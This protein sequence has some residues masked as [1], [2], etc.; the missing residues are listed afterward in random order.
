MG[1]NASSCSELPVLSALEELGSLGNT[2]CETKL[3][4]NPSQQGLSANQLSPSISSFER[5]IHERSCAALQ[6]DRQWRQAGRVCW[7]SHVQDMGAGAEKEPWGSANR[8]LAMHGS[9]HP[10]IPLSEYPGTAWGACAA[11]F[12]YCSCDWV[13][14]EIVKV[15]FRLRIGWEDCINALLLM[16]STG[17]PTIPLEKSQLSGEG[18]FLL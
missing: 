9:L 15:S 10:K 13:D 14:W 18:K 5:G 17:K 7:A 12:L 4:D 6:Q 2:V 16:L 3:R 11:K 8:Q 1:T